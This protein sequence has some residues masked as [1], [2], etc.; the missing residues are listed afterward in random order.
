MP[1]ISK[2]QRRRY[3]ER[4]A[5]CEATRTTERRALELRQSPQRYACHKYA[6]TTS[7]SSSSLQHVTQK[8]T[9]SGE[10]DIVGGLL[11]WEERVHGKE[12]AKS[13]GRREKIHSRSHTLNRQQQI[14]RSISCQYRYS[15]KTWNIFVI[16]LE[17]TT[18]LKK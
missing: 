18:S 12:T 4:S 17:N 8:M 9:A 13:Q 14:Q 11:K 3:A 2:E 15:T 7:Q 5:F 6:A 16:Q 1:K 10:A